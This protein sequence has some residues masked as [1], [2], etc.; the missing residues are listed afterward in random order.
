MP[1]PA[2]NVGC[3]PEPAQR[4]HERALTSGMPAGT[5]F[6]ID[7]SLNFH[8]G[9]IVTNN[10]Q[11]RVVMDSREVMSYYIRRGAI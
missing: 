6:V 8:V 11:R 4:R 1:I 5:I 9:F 7:L 3:V 2:S 10:F